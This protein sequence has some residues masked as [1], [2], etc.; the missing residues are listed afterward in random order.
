MN[1]EAADVQ[2]EKPTKPEHDQH[3]RQDDKHA[4]SFFLLSECELLSVDKS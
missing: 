1:K 3:N 2:D 4:R